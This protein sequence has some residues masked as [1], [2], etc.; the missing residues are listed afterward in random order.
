MPF[1]RHAFGL[2]ASMIATLLLATPSFAARCG[3]DFNGFVASVSAE[4]SA[5]LV[6]LRTRYY[7][8][9][10]EPAWLAVRTWALGTAAMP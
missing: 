3:G 10:S 1:F 7:D 9:D 8:F 2:C 6:V 5:N 4:A